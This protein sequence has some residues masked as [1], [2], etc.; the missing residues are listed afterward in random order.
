MRLMIYFKA[1]RPFLPADIDD[2]HGLLLSLAIVIVTCL[3]SLHFLV[4]GWWSYWGHSVL[5]E[6]K[7]IFGWAEMLGGVLPGVLKWGGIG[8]KWLA[9]HIN[10]YSLPIAPLTPGSEPATGLEPAITPATHTE[11]IEVSPNFYKLPKYVC[12]FV[13]L[14]WKSC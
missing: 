1:G 8:V 11:S 10:P 12:Y 5:E 7:N 13:H 2:L 3:F 14:S 6:R 9:H 4:F